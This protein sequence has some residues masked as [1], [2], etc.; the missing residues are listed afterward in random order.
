ME[1][2]EKPILEM[3]EHMQHQLMRWFAERRKI[4]ME[5]AQSQ[6]I[7]SKAFAKIQ[8]LTAFQARRYR[9]IDASPDKIFEILSLH[10]SKS[11][12]VKLNFDTCTCLEWESTGIPCSHAIAAIL[13]EKDNPQMYAKA[14][15]SL[16][17]YRRTYANAI[18]APDADLADNVSIFGSSNNNHGDKLAPPVLSVH[19]EDLE[20]VVFG[21]EWKVRSQI[22]GHIDVEGVGN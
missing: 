14:F 22:K 16:D 1:A 7:V 13:F 17:G 15:F 10:S 20:F 12:T 3:F 19:Q 8:E 18:L 5:V 2:R 21:V 6:I 9:I 4:D 11:Y